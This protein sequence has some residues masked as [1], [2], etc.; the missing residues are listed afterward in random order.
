MRTLL[1]FALLSL[2]FGQAPTPCKTP[3]YW[4]A[5]SRQWNP[6]KQ[7]SA[8]G[9]YYEDQV[10]LRKAW[11]GGVNT[12]APEPVEEWV[13]E[14]YNPANPTVPGFKYQIYPKN[15][16]CLQTMTNGGWHGHGIPQGATFLWEMIYGTTGLA[17]A[18]FLAQ[19]WQWA[20]G[21]NINTWTYT[22]NGCVP[23]NDVIKNNATGQMTST[24]WLDVIIGLTNPN[25]FVPPPFCPM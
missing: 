25:I 23:V 3:P 13:I 9:E 5:Y 18:G 15:Q 19:T 8:M 10:Q 14:L 2:A 24:Q 16:S 20:N 12:G 7:Q 17:N 11:T 6:Q 4:Q 21:A 22:V 1:V